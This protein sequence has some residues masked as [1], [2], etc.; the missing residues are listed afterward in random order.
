MARP[1]WTPTDA[2]RRQAE[3]MAAYGI[4]EADIPRVLGVSKP[5]IRG[6]VM[7]RLSSGTPAPGEPFIVG[8]RCVTYTGHVRQP[9][10]SG[11]PK[12][13]IGLLIPSVDICGRGK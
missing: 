4:P 12:R 6:T 10:F 9:K 7:A 2:Q 11:T 5:Y 8:L 1:V 13:R 3:T